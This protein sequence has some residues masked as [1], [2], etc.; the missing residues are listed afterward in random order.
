MIRYQ[1][2]RDGMFP[3]IVCDVCNEPIESQGNV[4]WDDQG[5]IVFTHMAPCSLKAGAAWPYS[6]PLAAFFA[7]LLH[8]SKITAKELKEG[9]VTN[10]FL[11]A[12]IG[13]KKLGRPR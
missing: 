2:S 5:Q 6:W 7:N 12:V 9:G 4:F 1:M 13:R 11:G 10:D 8:N 3:R